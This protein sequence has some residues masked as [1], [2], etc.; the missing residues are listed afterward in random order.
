MD[1]QSII[2]SF[3]T[4]VSAGKAAFFKKYGM[5]FVM[6]QRDGAW[7]HDMDGNKRL[8]N[9]HSNGGVFNLGHRNQ[10][11]IDTLRSALDDLDIGNHHFMSQERSA[12]AQQITSTMPDDLNVCIF[13]VGGGEAVDLA[14][15]LACGHTGRSKIISATGGFHGHTGLALTV[16]DAQYRD[17]FGIDATNKLQVP[18]NDA[19]ALAHAL[20]SDVAAV[21]LETIPATLGMVMPEDGY[22]EKVRALCDT[23]GTLLIMDEIQSGLGRTGKLWAFE[24]AGI[25]P[26]MVVIGKGLSGGIYPIAATIIREPLDTI[27]QNDPFI[28]ISTYGGSELGCRVAHKVIQISGDTIFLDRVQEAGQKVRE[29]LEV[30]LEK[31]PR[32]FTGIRQNGLMIGLELRDEYGGPALTKAAY[33]QDLLLVYANN[34]TSVSQFLLPLTITNEEIDLVMDKLDKAM[35]AARKLRTALIAKEKSNG[36]LKRFSGKKA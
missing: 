3:E 8:F 36:I 19:E 15:K 14:L 34:D 31:Y 20:D 25:T 27:F 2:K 23:N 7:I 33:D 28:H 4:H 12:L 9:C 13:S 26:D 32:F 22:L 29:G 11:I 24:H 1:K 5:D 10:E 16:G 21:I 30:I 35:N 17:A 6:G 18:F